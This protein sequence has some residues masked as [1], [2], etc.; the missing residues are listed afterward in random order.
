VATLFASSAI[1]A[2]V[3]AA[4]GAYTILVSTCS[5]YCGGDSAGLLSVGFFSMKFGFDP[6]LLANA[7]L[8]PIFDSGFFSGGFDSKLVLTGS[9]CAI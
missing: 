8:E 2:V 9:Y 4:I 3:F 6:S 7:G 5:Y 1:F